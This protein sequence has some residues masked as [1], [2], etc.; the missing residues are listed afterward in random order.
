MIS[1]FPFH[2]LGAATLLCA[3]GAAAAQ[4]ATLP[5]TPQAP[6]DVPTV[7]PPSATL[8]ARSTLDV[9]IAHGNFGS[10][11]PQGEAVNVRGV[12]RL[13]NGDVAQAEALQ[14]RKFGRQGGIVAGAYTRV[15]SPNWYATGTLALGHGGPNWADWR[16]DAQVSRKWLAQRQLVTSA[17]LYYARFRS[18]GSSAFSQREFDDFVYDTPSNPI[19]RY[20][21]LYTD[22]SDRGLR[23]SAAW[24]LPLPAVLEA[25]VT[26]NLSRPGDVDSRMPYV[27]ATIGREGEQYL[28]L[29]VASGTE[30]YQ[31]LGASRQLVNFR[32]DAVALTWRRWLGP[33]WGFTAQAEAYRNPT[34]RRQTTG[35]GVFVQW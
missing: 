26:F 9:G 6:P 17:A 19:T 13:G 1:R 21:V 28:G 27:A 35:V 30:A 8:P 14:E 11:L 32:S 29:R 25:G 4:T 10:G 5:P 2:R 31:A 7:T 24:Y 16:V 22:R 18:D 3:A 34:Y 15:L 33:R 20:R 12:W 23:L